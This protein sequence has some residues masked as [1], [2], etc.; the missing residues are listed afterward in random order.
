MMVRLEFSPA[1]GFSRIGAAPERYG[2]LLA[3]GTIVTYEIV[4]DAYTPEE[5]GIGWHCYLD[6]KLG[7]PFKGW[8]WGMCSD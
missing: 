6:D 4:V 8:R 1:G 7:F 5:R 2:M 3:R